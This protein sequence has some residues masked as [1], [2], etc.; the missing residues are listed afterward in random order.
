[1]CTKRLCLCVSFLPYVISSKVVYSTVLYLYDNIF[2][3]IS[4][5]RESTTDNPPIHNQDDSGIATTQGRSSTLALAITAIGVVVIVTTTTT[6]TTTTIPS[7]Q[8][9]ECTNGHPV[10]RTISGRPHND[11]RRIGRPLPLE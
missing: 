1:M 6:T 7:R 8:S 10:S 3:S 2:R 5:E 4:L 9:T 11:L